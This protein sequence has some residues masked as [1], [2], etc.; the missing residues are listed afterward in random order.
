MDHDL[1]DMFVKLTI[2][3]ANF[4]VGYLNSEGGRRRT[5][6]VGVP[7]LAG[8]ASIESVRRDGKFIDDFESELNSDER[9]ILAELVQG[10]AKVDSVV[11]LRSPDVIERE[12]NKN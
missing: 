8:D 7:N 10:S 5:M 3:K 1:C 11:Y 4:I 2:I 12:R 6:E 9:R